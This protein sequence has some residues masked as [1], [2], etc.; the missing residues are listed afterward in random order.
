LSAF[1]GLVLTN[2][3]KTL[4]AKAQAGAQ[5]KY[6]RI[7]VGDGELGASTII[8]L[9]AL[10]HEV[11]TLTIS[12]LQALTGGRALIGTTLSNN[13]LSSGFYWRELGIFALDPDV[14]EILYCYGNAGAL[15]EYIPIGG[16]ADL[17]EKSI[18]IEV[19]T[20][21]AANISAT[22]DNSL[23]YATVS[24][25]VE[26]KNCIDEVHQELDV[27][28]N[29]TVQHVVW[30]GTTTNVNNAYSVALNPV[31][32]SYKDGMGIAVKI[33]VNST[34]E[35]TLN[36]NGLGARPLKKTN[37]SDV[38]NL[39]AN[40][41]YT[42]RYN[43]STA[44]F[45]LQGEGG[46]GNAVAPDL[47]EGKTATTDAGEIIGSMINYGGEV[48]GAGEWVITSFKGRNTVE[49][50]IPDPGYYTSESI[51]A[52]S[53]PNHHSKNIKS[54]TEVYGVA[55]DSNVVDTSEVV[56]PV[57]SNE[58]L[59]GE[60]AFVNGAKIVG[61]MPN[62]GAV[63]I[64]P[65]AVVQSIPAGYHNGAGSVP[66]VVV[67][68]A[69]VLA[70]TTIAGTM[71]TMPNRGVGGTVVPSTADQT[72]T[73]GYYSSD[74]VIKGD[75]DLIAANI[76]KDVNIFG[77]IGTLDVAS[78]GGKKFAKGVINQPSNNAII[79]VSGLTFRPKYIL[80]FDSSNNIMV[81]NYDLS[82]TTYFAASQ[83]NPGY[84]TIT[85][86]A[87]SNISDTGFA[88]SRGY[89]TAAVVVTNWIAFE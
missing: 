67:P 78:L 39:K 46:S 73:S 54:G 79:R 1:G 59:S 42:F 44:N 10:K 72:K 70:G 86:D 69:N 16:G 17:I 75:S 88:L 2:V 87:D 41:I 32:T 49:V 40:G 9:T 43:L 4:Q 26:V 8:S 64:T 22:I 7:A 80:I 20:G 60:V 25:L 66:A 30:G 6:T 65:S 74:I 85:G 34:G 27:H 47:L 24:E 82:T 56:N 15:A 23:V 62:R 63:T 61:T 53:D 31:A 28:R 38:T 33:N 13:N 71:G 3:G 57:A 18:D 58:I 37:G 36:I 19:L 52:I 83:V 68:A 76:K 12:K 84:F 55:G 50:Y 5:L 14:G 45:I 11:K 48:L 21:N 89:N 51:L 29:D 35:S 77:V 81:Y